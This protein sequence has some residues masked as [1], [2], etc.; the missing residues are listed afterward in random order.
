MGNEIVLSRLA[1][2]YYFYVAVIITFIF[3]I[4]WFLLKKRETARRCISKVFML[5][6]SFVAGLISYKGFSFAS[7]TLE[8]D[9]MYILI[10]TIIIYLIVLIVSELISS[11]LR[12]HYEN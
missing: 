2:A 11:K 1:L 8:E 7:Y 4:V 5:T 9:L 3:L 10:R 12:F 6:G